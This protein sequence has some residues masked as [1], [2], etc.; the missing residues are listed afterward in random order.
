[1]L[2]AATLGG[3]VYRYDKN[4]ITS[5]ENTSTET[6]TSFSLEQNY[7]NPFN[8]ST[9]I[10]WQSPVGSHQTLK[11]YDVL[12][13]EV[14]TLVDEFRVAGRYEINFDATGLASG[15]YLYRIQAGSFVETK[16]MILLK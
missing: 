9:K 10:S 8:P 15:I 12:G 5:V 1:Y 16:K 7:P 4:N 11:I 3:G 2:Y 14:A 6:P 13:N